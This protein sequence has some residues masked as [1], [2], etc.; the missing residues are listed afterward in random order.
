MDGSQ[1]DGIGYLRLNM[2]VIGKWSAIKPD[3]RRKDTLKNTEKT[4][5][6]QSHL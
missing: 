6:R 2:E 5:M 4:T 3:L 1:L